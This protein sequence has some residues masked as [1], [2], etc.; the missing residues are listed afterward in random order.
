[1]HCKTNSSFG[2]PTKRL[3]GTENLS[4]IRPISFFPQCIIDHPI[5]VCCLLW[6]NA[7][8]WEQKFLKKYWKCVDVAFSL[9]WICR[10][11]RYLTCARRK[12]SEVFA[13]VVAWAFS[14]ALYVLWMV[15]GNVVCFLKRKLVLLVSF[16]GRDVLWYLEGGPLKLWACL[17]KLCR[18]WSWRSFYLHGVVESSPTRE[19]LRDPERW[20]LNTVMFMMHCDA[21][22]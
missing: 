10:H 1:M 4:R 17:C 13:D 16:S 18:P 7:Y 6:Q 5:I 11:C 14:K 3:L 12:A 20:G 22:K 9:S 21:P 8:T 2:P 15:V 19:K